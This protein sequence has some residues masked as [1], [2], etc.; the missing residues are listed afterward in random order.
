MK[1]RKR[2]RDINDE[3]KEKRAEFSG[4]RAVERGYFG[5]RDPSFS[6]GRHTVPLRFAFL[7]SRMSPPLSP[8]LIASASMTA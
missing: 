6:K 3:E 7:P 5:R 2:R 1:E 4:T 8:R